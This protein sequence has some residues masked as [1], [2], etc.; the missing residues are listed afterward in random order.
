MKKN[1]YPLRFSNEVLNTVTAYE[2][3]SFLNGYLG[4]HQIFIVIE[5]RYKIAFVTN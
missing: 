4:Y 1:P 3:Y 2:A 5:D